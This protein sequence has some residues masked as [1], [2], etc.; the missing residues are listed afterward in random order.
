MNIARSTAA[1]E[2]G[3]QAAIAGF[4]PET[5]P[6]EAQ[7][8]EGR[9]WM[10]GWQSATDRNLRFSFVRRNLKHPPDWAKDTLLDW[11]DC[12]PE[13]KRAFVTLEHWSD[14]RM[15]GTGIDVFR[16]VG[17]THPDYV[18]K[19]WLDLLTS[20]KRMTSNLELLSE[21]PG[22]YRDEF[23][24]KP[25]D[26]LT[27]DGERFYVGADGNHRTCI[28]RFFLD[29][30]PSTALEN[31]E[32]T[33]YRVD[34]PFY[35]LYREATAFIDQHQLA[36]RIDPLRRPVRR[37]DGPGWKVDIHS[38]VLR[39]HDLQAGT[40]AELDLEQS[41]ARFERLTRWTLPPRLTGLLER[42]GRWM[43]GRPKESR[44]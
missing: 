17:T 8:P 34:E 35:A 26:Y 20:G 15:S 19:T 40:R 10:Q 44:A 21:N 33:R 29:G 13:D 30:G 7:S 4:L 11:N 16:V 2:R 9:S 31:V 32:I 6:Y 43:S 3:Y 18:G 22:Y 36:I 25:M 39:W 27:L 23:F 41:R 28:A 24:G 12:F 1:Y 37:E 42:I 38:V 14:L 5:N